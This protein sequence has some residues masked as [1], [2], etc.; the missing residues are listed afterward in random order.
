MTAG[1]R[2]SVEVAYAWPTGTFLRTVEVRNPATI[3]DVVEASGLLAHRP[4]VDLTR[5]RV[6]I[7][8]RIATLDSPVADGDRVEVYR[9]LVADPKEARRSRAS[10]RK[11][12]G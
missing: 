2:I 1:Q 12:R 9:P 10:A 7:W 3:R 5:N 6:G 4:E 8:S 11:R